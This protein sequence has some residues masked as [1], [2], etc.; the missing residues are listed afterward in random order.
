M[1]HWCRDDAGG[2]EWTDD[3]TVRIAQGESI[4]SLV[5]YVNGALREEKPWS[6]VVVVL[7]RRFALTFD[8]AELVW[9]RVQGG[10][11]RAATGNPL[12]E[13]DAAKDP[14]AWAAYRIALG[15]DVSEEP[16]TSKSVA[17]AA[18]KIW[19]RA[20]RGARTQ[21]FKDVATALELTQRALATDDAGAD[22]ARALLDA[23]T[24]I[25][26][27]GE[28]L[29][30]R[31][32]AKRCAPDGSQ[33]W[34]D[35]VALATA[36]RQLAERFGAQPDPDL[37]D[38][39]YQLAGRIV[40]GLLGQ[41][42]AHVGWAM[43]D[44]ARCA[45]RHGEDERA[46]DFAKSL[47]GDFAVLVDGTVDELHVDH[48]RIGLECLLEAIDIKASAEGS[49]AELSDLQKRTIATLQTISK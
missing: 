39:A 48:H 8:D 15:H 46:A 19:Q 42:F 4:L 40:T 21:G 38:R 36:A 25:S 29:I 1:R 44:S 9:D 11:T 23:A 22:M 26:V 49:T 24:Y 31:L 2:I 27:A 41:S 5:T 6:D 32:G 43:L 18:Q 33:D 30:D 3:M 37:E 13:P 12:N 28:A 34:V 14:V 7:A 17:G 20:K 16:I 45:L 10:A 35:G 47:I